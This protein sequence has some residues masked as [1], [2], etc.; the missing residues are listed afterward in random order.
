MLLLSDIDYSA[1][2][3]I[4]ILYLLAEI[5]FKIRKIFFHA[6]EV[7]LGYRPPKVQYSIQKPIF[8]QSEADS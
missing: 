1:V 4:L 2:Y 6:H 7:Q 5:F 3:L 8:N